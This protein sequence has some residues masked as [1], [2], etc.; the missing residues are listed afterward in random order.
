MTSARTPAPSVKRGAALLRRNTG[1]LATAATQ[2]MEAED[3]FRHL[4][5]EDRSWV[6]VVLQTGI[7][8]FVDW[9]AAG[10]SSAS[11]VPGVTV[12]VFSAAPR[13]L[14]GVISLRQTVDLVRLSIEVVESRLDEIL[15]PDDAPSAHEAIVRFA[16]EVAFATAEVYARAA[17][18]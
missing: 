1:R 6:G 11:G 9:Y 13:A 16:R 8:S 4:S 10:L 15:G 17:E 18:Q 2:R 7:R 14:A 5:A 3:W 12:D